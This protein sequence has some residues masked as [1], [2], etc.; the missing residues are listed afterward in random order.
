MP[1][2]IRAI[3]VSDVRNKC[4]ESQGSLLNCKSGMSKEIGISLQ[5]C[6]KT[7]THFVPFERIS[8][9]WRIYIC[10]KRNKP[11]AKRSWMRSFFL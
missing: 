5:S 10:N 7:F 1:I 6:F 11:S 4:T 2:F 9:A 3:L 8:L